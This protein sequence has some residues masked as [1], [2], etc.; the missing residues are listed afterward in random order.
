MGNT[1]S[2]SSYYKCYIPSI[3]D[4]DLELNVLAILNKCSGDVRI[5]HDEKYFASNPINFAE[6]IIAVH[7]G[8][9]HL[10]ELLATGMQLFINSFDGKTSVIVRTRDKKILAK[11]DI[12]FDVGKEYNPEK[13][14]YD[15]H[16]PDFNVT[17]PN[18]KTKLSSAGLFWLNQGKELISKFFD[19]NNQT[20]IEKLWFKVYDEYI[21]QVD[22]HDNGIKVANE[23][24]FSISSKASM[25]SNPSNA[26]EEVIEQYFY[27]YLQKV[28]CDF[29]EYLLKIKSKFLP[30]REIIEQ[31]FKHRFIHHESGKVLV[32]P[33]YC[34]SWKEHLFDIE[35]ENGVFEN[36]LFVIFFDEK[37]KTW[38]ISAVPKKLQS[39][40][41]RVSLPRPWC[42][43]EPENYPEVIGVQECTFVHANGFIGGNKTFDGALQMAKLAIEFYRTLYLYMGPPGCGKSTHAKE[44]SFELGYHHEEADRLHVVNGIY[45]FN[46]ANVA[47]FHQQTILN[48]EE[49]M[50]NGQG[51]IVANTNL[52]PSAVKPYFRL[53]EKYNYKFKILYPEDYSSDENPIW[54]NGKLNRKLI[55]QRRKLKEGDSEKEHTN[56]GKR[57][58]LEVLIRMMNEFDLNYGKMTRETILSAPDFKK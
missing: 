38:R 54:V 46:P 24:K 18:R 44:L 8:T 50:K 45:K 11:C 4:K 52:T 55:E 14:L 16:M 58:Q 23:M 12:V 36:T 25:I 47:R 5:Y 43:C 9:Y 30:E 49:L 13:N 3:M 57:L 27:F 7:S 33:K 41:D 17:M 1:I 6:I 53:A 51:V 2:K 35:K 19:T 37:D 28:I 56:E 26:S 48:C 10:D 29:F 21:E 40:G 34:S 15:H 31:A 42:Q 22:A 20:L 32:L 39:F